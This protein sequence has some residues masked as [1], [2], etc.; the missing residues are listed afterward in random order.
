[1]CQTGVGSTLAFL[2]S[3]WSG[4]Y[5]QIGGLTES[6]EVLDNTALGDKREKSCPGSTIRTEVIECEIF[7]DTDDPPPIN[8][9]KEA[10]ILTLTPKANQTTG[11]KI[12]GNGFITSRTSP[13]LTNDGLLM[14]TFQLKLDLTDNSFIDGA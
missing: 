1:M 2:I 7:Y 11:A 4:R 10:I 13:V 8:A 5:R 9:A 3:G 6:R 14:G 12:S